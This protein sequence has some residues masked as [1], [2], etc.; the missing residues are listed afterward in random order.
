MAEHGASEVGTATGVDYQDHL[1]TYQSFLRATR[2][3]VVGIVILLLF[4][5]WWVF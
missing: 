3:G 4:L 5:T 2:Y 1:Q